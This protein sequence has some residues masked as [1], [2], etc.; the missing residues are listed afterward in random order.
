MD[1][2]RSLTRLHSIQR[3]P[4]FGGE[5]SVFATVGLI[6]LNQL[7]NIGA[8]TGFA[9][10]G[11][12]ETFKAFLLWQIIGSAFGLGVQLS[13]AGLVRVSSVQLANAVGIGLAFV[14]AEVF[15]AYGIFRESFSLA[16]W[17]GVGLVFSGIMF[18]VLGRT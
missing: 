7:M 1:Y 11:R 12:G 6:A 14:S 2:F 9:I 8:T 18:L 17:L 13:F 3:A 4:I 15:S 10:S 5:Y 16:Q